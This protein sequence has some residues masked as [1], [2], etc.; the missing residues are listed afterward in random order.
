M[1]LENLNLDVS[2]LP[3]FIVLFITSFIRPGSILRGKAGFL[4]WVKPK[5]TPGKLRIA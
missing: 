2:S 3:N 1:R 4:L 5:P